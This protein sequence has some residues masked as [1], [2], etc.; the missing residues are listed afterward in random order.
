MVA[1]VSTHHQAEPDKEVLVM[2]EDIMTEVMEADTLM[3]VENHII[4][5]IEIQEKEGTE[6]GDKMQEII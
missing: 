2:E 1:M 6:E 4:D 5:K 3:V